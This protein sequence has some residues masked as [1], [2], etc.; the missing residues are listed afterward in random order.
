MDRTHTLVGEIADIVRREVKYLRHYWGEVLRTDD[1]KSKGRVLVSVPMLGWT[2]QDQGPWC[3]PRDRHAMVVPE[4]GEHV[5]VYFIEG[6]RNK[7]VYLGQ[8][9]EIGAQTPSSYIDP[10]T[11]VI[12]ESAD[13]TLKIVVDKEAGTLSINGDFIDLNGNARTMVTFAELT[14]ALASF[15]TSIDTAIAGAIT[16]H[17]HIYSPGGGGPIVTAAGVG[18]APGTAVDISASE[19]ATIRTG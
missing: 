10:N 12:Y 15:K 13:G 2:T 9:H 6:D 11:A 3:Q 1:S 17:T 19:A 16:G 4:I 14:S 7:P 5:E 8:A 18:S